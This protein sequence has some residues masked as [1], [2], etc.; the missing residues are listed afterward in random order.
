MKCA[1]DLTASILAHDLPAA[2]SAPHRTT[3]FSNSANLPGPA[4]DLLT[5]EVLADTFPVQ[6]RKLVAPLSLPLNAVIFLWKLAVTHTQR[7]EGL[8][9]VSTSNSEAQ[10]P[11]S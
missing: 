1:P 5:R 3:A 2:E 11:T 10:P 9:G 6:R 7:R 8:E 4:K